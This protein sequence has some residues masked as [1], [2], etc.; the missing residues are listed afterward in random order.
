MKVKDTF[1]EEV[2]D[3][4]NKA[5]KKEGPLREAQLILQFCPVSALAFFLYLQRQASAPEQV[6]GGKQMGGGSDLSLRIVPSRRPG[7]GRYSSSPD[8][9]NPKEVF[10]HT[11]RDL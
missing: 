7:W 3:S 4:P 2:G 6:S 5:A 1:F 9:Q 10:I 11:E 8:K